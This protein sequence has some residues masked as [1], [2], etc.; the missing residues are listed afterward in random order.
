M[1]AKVVGSIVWDHVSVGSGATVVNS[2]VMSNCRIDRNREEYN[3]VLTENISHPI[4][5]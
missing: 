5:V 4:A 2:V 3:I 1:R